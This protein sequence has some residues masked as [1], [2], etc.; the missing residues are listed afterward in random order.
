MPQPNNDSHA[1]DTG[2]SFPA[3]MDETTSILGGKLVCFHAL[4]HPIEET[5]HK[6]PVVL[7]TESIPSPFLTALHFDTAEE[8]LQFCN[9]AN[10]ALQLSRDDILHIVSSSMFPRTPQA[11]AHRPRPIPPAAPPEHPGLFF[12]PALVPAHRVLNITLIPKRRPRNP[13]TNTPQPDD[14]E[15]FLPSDR[16]CT[17]FCT[18]GITTIFHATHITHAYDA[19][20]ALNSRL[21]LPESCW[22]STQ[23]RTI[24]DDV[25]HR[26]LLA[27]AAQHQPPS[28]HPH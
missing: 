8:A 5:P 3:E 24:H 20:N 18:P 13:D 11:C 19:C 28:E 27:P 12:F 4:G 22:S 7:V 17:T 14:H 16:L 15:S 2:P 10:D 25:A 23:F 6:H 21:G 26:S 9:R 1:R